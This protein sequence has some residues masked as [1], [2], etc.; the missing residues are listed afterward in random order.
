[1]AQHISAAWDAAISDW[2]R[3]QRSMHSLR[4]MFA[5][6]LDDLP[7]VDVLDIQQL[8]GHASLDVTRR[9]IPR[10]GDRLRD[11]VTRAAVA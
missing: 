11:A 7:G 10:R 6:G 9:Y 8:L 3:S 5:A 1:M 4:H 2:L